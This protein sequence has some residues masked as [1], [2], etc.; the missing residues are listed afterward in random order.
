MGRDDY[1]KNTIVFVFVNQR[2]VDNLGMENKQTGEEVL[3]AR[4][5]NY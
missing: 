5:Q 4:T 3:Q 1:R 2:A